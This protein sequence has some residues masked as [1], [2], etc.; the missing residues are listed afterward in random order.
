MFTHTKTRHF[1][2]RTDAIILRNHLNA[3]HKHD[4]AGPEMPFY[5]TIIKHAE[6]FFSMDGLWKGKI[7]QLGF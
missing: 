5:Y 4:L 6:V 7:K 1:N 2:Q 3:R